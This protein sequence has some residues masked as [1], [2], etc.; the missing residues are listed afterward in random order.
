MNDDRV[1]VGNIQARLDDRCGYQNIDLAADKIIHDLFQLGFLHLSV[2]IS[3]PGLRNQ[4][5]N[6]QSSP[7]YIIDTVM[8]IVDLAFAG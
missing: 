6:F 4:V 2:G 7:G 3:H 5:L 8:D 1:D